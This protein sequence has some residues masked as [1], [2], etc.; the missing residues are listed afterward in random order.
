M[1]QKDAFRHAQKA[2][3]LDLRT[4]TG[5]LCMRANDHEDTLFVGLIEAA[6]HIENA[7]CNEIGEP[8]EQRAKMCDHHFPL[9]G[10]PSPRLPRRKSD[11]HPSPTPTIASASTVHAESK[12]AARSK[13][14]E[15]PMKLEL[16][17]QQRR[18]ARL[19]LQVRA[20][21]PMEWDLGE[22]IAARFG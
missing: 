6:Q 5:K 12:H 22:T 7:S 9:T 11:S 4:A 15:L 13:I 2:I 19:A 1:L 17:G 16:S 10:N 18:L 14:V 3:Q 21:A 20:L 8:K